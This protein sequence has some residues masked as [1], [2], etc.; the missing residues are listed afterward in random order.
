MLLRWSSKITLLVSLFGFSSLSASTDFTKDVHPLIT[1]KCD[2]E[3]DILL[4]TNILLKDGKE[5]NF[6]YSDSD[7]TYSPWDMVEIKDNQI[8]DSR[9]IKKECQLGSA[10][11]SI[12]LEP[13]IFNN[14]L[15]GKCGATIST[16]ITILSNN[17]ELQERKAFEFYCTGNTKIITGVKVIGKTGEIKIREVPRYK[18]Y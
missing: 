11:Y 17:K 3:K 2:T 1:Y 4:V 10:K 12:I 9:S 5:K 6:Q 18:Y 7:G 8:I 16:A 14:N 13:Q 15:D